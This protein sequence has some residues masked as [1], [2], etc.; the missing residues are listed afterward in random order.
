MSGEH[1]VYCS[2]IL[3]RAC[4]AFE[5]RGVGQSR[6]KPLPLSPCRQHSLH[7]GGILLYTAMSFLTPCRT[8]LLQSARN[9][10][11]SI[12]GR[13]VLA[14]QWYQQR[15]ASTKHPKGFQP[16]SQHDLDELRERTIEFARREIPNEVAQQVDHS[17]EFPNEMWK[18]MGEAGFLGITADEDYGG[19]A[20]GYQAHCTVMEE[21]SRASGRSQDI[22]VAT[23]AISAYIWQAPS[24]SPMQRI[25]NSA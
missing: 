7:N 25:A 16:P 19:L 1:F 6:Y 14:A 2:N 21:L 5:R 4:C 23:S 20:M 15:Y 18:K 10:C 9:A 22:V 24:H 13:R 11:P 17:N 3:S 12:A 8:A